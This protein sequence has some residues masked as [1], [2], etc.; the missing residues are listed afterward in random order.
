MGVSAYL[1]AQYNHKCLKSSYTHQH[2]QKEIFCRCP[3]CSFPQNESQE[4]GGC[5]VSKGK[6]THHKTWQKS[7]IVWFIQ[8]PLKWYYI[9]TWG[10]AQNCSPLCH[11][12][13]ICVYPTIGEDV[14][15]QVWHQ[16]LVV[17]LIFVIHNL[18]QLIWWVI[19][20]CT[21]AVEVAK[22]PFLKN[23]PTWG[24]LLQ[25]L[26]GFLP[27]CRYC[28]IWKLFISIIEH[29]LEWAMYLNVNELKSL[30][31]PK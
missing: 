26:P 6:K 29:H 25:R 28:V 7:I 23:S 22:D 19:F 1:K 13:L 27:T 9:F 8:S 12:F 17:Q 21:C 16:Q 31:S 11:R 14:L 20:E 18:M 2:L 15:H 24:L 5:Q 3:S 30:I 10:T 4:N